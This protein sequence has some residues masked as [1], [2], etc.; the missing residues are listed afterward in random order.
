VCFLLKNTNMTIEEIASNVGYENIS[1][2]Y[3]LFKKRY[4]TSPKK[5]KDS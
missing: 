5:Y 2:F 1:F 3:R 4:G